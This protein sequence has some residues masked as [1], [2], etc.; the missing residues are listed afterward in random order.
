MAECIIDEFTYGHQRSR[1]ICHPDTRKELFAKL[2]QWE[3]EKQGKEQIFW[4]KDDAGCGKS[5]VASTKSSDWM[6][7]KSMA[8]QMYCPSDM[9]EVLQ[10]KNI[11]RHIAVQLVA[12]E[13]I[14]ELVVRLLRETQIHHHHP[15]TCFQ[16]L[17]SDPLQRLNQPDPVFLIIDAVDNLGFDEQEDLLKIL[18]KQLPKTPS[19]KVLITSRQSLDIIHDLK[20]EGLLYGLSEHSVASDSSNAD[21]IKQ[22]V[23]SELRQSKFSDRD[24]DA[25]I[26]YS[27]GHFEIAAQLCH[28]L[29]RSRGHKQIVEALVS[30]NGSMEGVDGLHANT[31]RQAFKDKKPKEREEALHVLR[32]L[33]TCF[34]PLSIEGGFS[35]LLDRNKNDRNDEV[36]SLLK[37][38]QDLAVLERA[39]D[40]Q[41]L[42]LMNEPFKQF[43]CSTLSPLD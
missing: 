26:R 18:A 13:S 36:A 34:E 37:V 6:L 33:V 43:V 2:Q 5:T 29:A 35:H 25:V 4:I 38:F 1:P 32:V 7:H 28:Q 39:N 23:Y 3:Q 22:Y 12:F 16:K 31:L 24:R 27:D 19:V 8:A 20:R 40:E 14:R 42:V 10:I 30:G 15:S 9:N 11:I 21:D 17:I 41:P